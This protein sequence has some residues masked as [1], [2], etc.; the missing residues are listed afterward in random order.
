[1]FKISKI[2]P[3]MIICLALVLATSI[4]TVVAF[5]NENNARVVPQVGHGIL[6]KYKIGQ[7][8]SRDIPINNN[9]DN[10]N[11]YLICC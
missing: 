9:M 2:K 10:I 7:V 5:S 11:I 4:I 3:I 8:I 1:M 6:I